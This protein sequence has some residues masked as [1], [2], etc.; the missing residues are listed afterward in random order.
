MTLM[1]HLHSPP[2]VRRVVLPSSASKPMQSVGSPVHMQTSP[3]CHSSTLLTNTLIV[4]CPTRLM[5]TESKENTPLM[6]PQR[7]PLPSA[8]TM[9]SLQASKPLI[10][11]HDPPTSPSPLLARPSPASLLHEKSVSHDNSWGSLGN[12]VLLDAMQ[13]MGE[14]A[15][16]AVHMFNSSQLDNH[17]TSTLMGIMLMVTPAPTASPVTTEKAQIK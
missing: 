15:A 9:A 6:P 7:D 3:Q 1:S 8:G 11:M 5:T 13:K 17:T 12:D 4:H 2:Q 10:R 14:D 16:S